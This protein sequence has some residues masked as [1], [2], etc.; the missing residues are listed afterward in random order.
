MDDFTNAVAFADPDASNPQPSNWNID[1]FAK[2]ID[3][4]ADNN[5][6]Y[7]CGIVA[8]SQGEWQLCISI[9]ITGAALI[10]LRVEAK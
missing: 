4:F 3:K 5:D 9:T 1:Q 8:H 6:I 2:K 7:G 10:A